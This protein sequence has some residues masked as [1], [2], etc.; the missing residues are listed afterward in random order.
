[1]D[2]EKIESGKSKMESEYNED[3]IWTSWLKIKYVD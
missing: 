2:L 3:K 1:M